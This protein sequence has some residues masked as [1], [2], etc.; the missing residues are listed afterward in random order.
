MR[1]RGFRADWLQQWSTIDTQF[2]NAIRDMPPLGKRQTLEDERALF[3]QMAG[4]I[5]DAT[6]IRL[7]GEQAQVFLDLPPVDEEKE[8][9]NYVEWLRLPFPSI[10]IELES[11]LLFKD[12]A[13][14]LLWSQEGNDPSRVPIRGIVMVERPPWFSRYVKTSAGRVTERITVDKITLYDMQ[15]TQV[16]APKSSERM[17]QI[18]WLIPSRDREYPE[19]FLDFHATTIVVGQDNKLYQTANELMPTRRRATNFMISLVNF[20]TS[21]SVKLVR[22]EPPQALQKA[23]TKRGKEPLPGWYEITYR[24]LIQEYTK[25]KISEKKWEH[26]FRYDVRGHF[27]TFTRGRMAGRRIWIPPHQRGLKH[28]LYKPKGYRADP[29]STE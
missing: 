15:G 8:P 25:D 28:S 26:S 23:R 20:L 1:S 9:Q 14:E 21:P 7:R 12:D 27:A 18:S 17:L 11:P 10:Y 4:R 22:N 29:Q 3:A 13:G 6:V 16:P 19:K 24:K 5:K 2:M